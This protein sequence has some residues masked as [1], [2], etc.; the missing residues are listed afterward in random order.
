MLPAAIGVGGVF[1]TLAL[2]GG[3]RRIRV[4]AIVDFVLSLLAILEELES[5]ASTPRVEE[6]PLAFMLLLVASLSVL[7]AVV[8]KANITRLRSIALTICVIVFAGGGGMVA[9]MSP[10]ESVGTSLLIV[11][12]SWILLPALTGLAIPYPSGTRQA[13]EEPR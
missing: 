13:L 5:G 3:R 8:F 2:D 10:T 1:L 12:V 9:L 6:R 7:I 4:S 11:L